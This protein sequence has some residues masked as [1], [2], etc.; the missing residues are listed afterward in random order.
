MKFKRI[1]SAMVFI[2]AAGL[3]PESPAM[4]AVSQE[5][6]LSPA[7]AEK[8]LRARSRLQDGW[9]TRNAETMKEA[10]DQFL[11]LLLQSQSKNPFLLYYAGLSE[12]RLTVHAFS[13][14]QTEEAA[15]TSSRAVKFF[16]DLT[17]LRPD[18]GEPYAL[19]ATCLGFEIALNPSLGMELGMETM[20]L[21]NRAERLEPENPRVRYLKAASLMY[22]PAEFGG[23]TEN[24]LPLFQEAV[25]LFDKGK[26]AGPLEPTWGKEEAL[27]LLA[28]IYKNRGE[29]EKAL[30][31]LNKALAANPNYGLARKMLQE[32]EPD[33]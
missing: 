10:R 19:T 9:N 30:D 27:T 7:P 33:E 21:F 20:S 8:I 22:W 15:A 23:G 28:G 29:K 13:S 16:E 1:V 26:P 3:F 32:L 17:R 12:Y 2:I 18:W 31:C 25:G 14:G 24:A 4:A 11:G 5:T 6:T